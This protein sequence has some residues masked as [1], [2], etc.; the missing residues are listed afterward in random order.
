MEDG[1]ILHDL[2][3]F[4]LLGDTIDQMEAMK[5]E[6]PQ[7]ILHRMLERQAEAPV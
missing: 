3:V 4:K 6:D 5:L 1:A 7:K 2:T